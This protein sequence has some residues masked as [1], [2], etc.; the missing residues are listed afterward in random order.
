MSSCV[1][2]IDSSEMGAEKK[3]ANN[4]A[5]IATTDYD[6]YKNMGFSRM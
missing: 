6:E 4:Y 5:M 3:S 2:I 1:K